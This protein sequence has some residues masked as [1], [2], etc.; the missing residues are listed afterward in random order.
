[1][2]EVLLIKGEISYSLPFIRG[3]K[4]WGK[5]YA[6]GLILVLFI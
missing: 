6:K 2:G 3:G 5:T 4:G 1:V